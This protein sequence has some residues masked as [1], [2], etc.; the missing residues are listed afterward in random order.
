MN[1]MI[2]QPFG[3]TATQRSRLRDRLASVAFDP[4][5]NFIAPIE[6]RTNPQTAI[7]ARLAIL[8]ATYH[9]D[10]HTDSFDIERLS[11]AV[12]HGDEAIAFWGEPTSINRLRYWLASRSFAP[13]ARQ[14]AELE[15]GTATLLNVTAEMGAGHRELC[16]GGSVCHTISAIG[17]I[18]SSLLRPQAIVESNEDF[19]TVVSVVRNRRSVPGIAGGAAVHRLHTR[20]LQSSF[21]GFAPWYVMQGGVL[22]LLDYREIYRDS[23]AVRTAVAATPGVHLVD[24][25]EASFVTDLLELNLA[26]IAP[27]PPVVMSTATQ[28]R[29]STW[30]L[31]DH[32]HGEL[33]GYNHVTVLTV[34]AGGLPLKE[35]LSLPSTCSA[36]C[37]VARI[38]LSADHIHDQVEL[39]KH[40][41]SLTAVS[42][43]KLVESESLFYGFWSR[44]RRDQKFVKPYYVDSQLLSTVEKRIVSYM[45]GMVQTC[46]S[47]ANLRA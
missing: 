27:S 15:L 39:G 44:P 28:A 7:R 37:V 47:S 11:R 19:H 36:A 24:Y 38:P 5:L 31:V 18:I 21:W 12:E 25:S 17:P 33:V 10:Y 26:G 9:D 20:E 40:G 45:E 29:M 35:L 43:P 6:A 41:F 32:P 22:E 42:P 30:R 46:S 34:P 14:L 23:D 2:G 8:L 1:G 3:S 13:S 16:R 4:Q